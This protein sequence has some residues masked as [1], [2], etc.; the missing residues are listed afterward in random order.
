MTRLY[1]IPQAGISLTSHDR[2][3]R[4][5]PP[6]PPGRFGTP[7]LSARPF[8]TIRLQ[9]PYP[10]QMGR[11]HLSPSSPTFPLLSPAAPQESSRQCETRRA[12]VRRREPRDATETRRRR[13]RDRERRCG[14]DTAETERGDA[15]ETRRRL[16]GDG[17]ETRPRHKGDTAETRRRRGG[18]VAETQRRHRGDTEETPAAGGGLSGITGGQRRR[19]RRGCYSTAARHGILLWRNRSPER[20][21]W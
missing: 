9:F 10:S 12:P 20:S 16:G 5:P 14:R 3:S 1:I 17:E 18:D 8:N 11:S 7:L 13:G 19:L 21:L 2:I 4:P 15:A 6:S